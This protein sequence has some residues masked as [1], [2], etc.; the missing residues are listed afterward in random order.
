MGRV[1]V[2]IAFVPE[3]VNLFMLVMLLVFILFLHLFLLLLLLFFLPV[4]LVLILRLARARLPQL[5]LVPVLEDSLRLFLLRLTAKRV[6][7]SALADARGWL[8]LP[9]LLL[10][11]GCLTHE[12]REVPELISLLLVL[13][14]EVLDLLLEPLYGRLLLGLLGPG[15]LGNPLQLL[16]QALDFLSLLL[17]RVTHQLEVLGALL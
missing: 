4:S 16:A 13:Y 8:V 12:L 7:A 3:L 9:L 17:V 15:L 2:S 1:Q 11:R 14:G 5:T 6:A 10:R